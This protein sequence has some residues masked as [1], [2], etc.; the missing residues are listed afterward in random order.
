[1][2]W[3]HISDLLRGEMASGVVGN[4]L[5]RLV[6][7]AFLGGVIGLERELKHRPAGL[8]TNMFI[9]FGAALFTVLSGGW[10]PSLATTPASRRKLSPASASSARVRFCIRADLQLA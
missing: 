5:T 3:Q 8:R 10:R 9:C 6:P 2:N 4:S 7:A 1:M